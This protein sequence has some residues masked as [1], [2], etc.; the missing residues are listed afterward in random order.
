MAQNPPLNKEA[1]HWIDAHFRD[2]MRAVRGV[3]DMIALLVEKLEEL[4]GNSKGK[5]QLNF[6]TKNGFTSDSIFNLTC[7]KCHFFHF[8]VV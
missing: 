7:L 5:F 2:R 8:F 4:G 3:D 1:E 6:W